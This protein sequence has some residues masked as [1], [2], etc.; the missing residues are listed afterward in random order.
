MKPAEANA[1][2]ATE[3]AG[4]DSAELRAVMVN[5]IEALRAK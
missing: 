1:P 4:P 5:P 3:L 2:R